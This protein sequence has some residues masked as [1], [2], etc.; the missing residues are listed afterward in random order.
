MNGLIRRYSMQE[1][2]PFQLIH[3]HSKWLG[4]VSA[5]IHK[6]MHDPF[7]KSLR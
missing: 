7:L 3:R 4:M 2:I 6:L 1:I 5:K